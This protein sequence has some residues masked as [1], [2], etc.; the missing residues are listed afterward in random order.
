MADQRL[1]AEEIAGRLGVAVSTVRAYAARGFMPK[2]SACPCCGYGAT[3]DRKEIEAWI[4]TRPGKAGR[5][6]RS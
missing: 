4:A 6:K 5:P 1:T 3:W 2:A